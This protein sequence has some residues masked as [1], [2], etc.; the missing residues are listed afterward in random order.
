MS[1]KAFGEVKPACTWVEA[2]R[3]VRL[4]MLVEIRRD[5]VA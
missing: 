2:G 3:M 4:D 5:R 1:S